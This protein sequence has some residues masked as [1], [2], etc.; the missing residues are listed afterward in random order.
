MTTF[1]YRAALLALLV[2]SMFLSGCDG[3]DDRI[4]E[5]D[6]LRVVAVRSSQSYARPGST[7]EL[8]ML[9]RDASPKAVNQQGVARDVTLLWMGSCINPAGDLYY[10]CLPALHES[11]QGITDEEF[12]AGSFSEATELARLG[13]GQ[14]YELALPSDIITS[15]PPSDQLV[16]P[17]GVAFV[18]YAACA[19]EL[20]ILR[21]A[22]PEND[23]PVSCFDPVTGEV[24]GQSDFEFGYYPLYAYDELNNSNPEI[25]AVVFGAESSDK[26]CDSAADCPTGEACGSSKRCIMRVTACSTGEDCSKFEFRPVVESTSVEAAASAHIHEA[27]APRETIWV[28]YYSDYGTFEKESRIIHESTSGMRDDYAGFWKPKRNGDSPSLPYEAH[29]YAVVRDSRGGVTW[30][31][32]EVYIE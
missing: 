22:D 1:K 26:A 4:S 25:T 5:L 8:E 31:T 2:P 21:D 17:Y 7:V 11:F 15:R 30:T 18:F 10:N 12:A 20:R 3:E 6:S 27:S 32:R 16:Y 13:F 29:L 24:L 23:Y 28:S 14:R 19:G 9:L